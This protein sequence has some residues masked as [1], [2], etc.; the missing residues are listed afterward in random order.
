MRVWICT[1]RVANRE[2]RCGYRAD[3][4]GNDCSCTLPDGRN[5]PH[6]CHYRK[7]TGS[8]GHGMRA[9][10][11]QGCI[12]RSGQQGQCH[13]FLRLSHCI[14]RY[15]QWQTPS[16]PIE[17]QGVGVHPPHRCAKSVICRGCCSTC[18]LE[19]YRQAVPCLQGRGH[20]YSCCV[21]AHRLR[22]RAGCRGETHPIGI[23]K[24]HRCHG[25]CARMHLWRQGT[26]GKGHPLAGLCLCICQCIHLHDLSGLP[27]CKHHDDTAVRSRLIIPGCR[28]AS[29][30]MGQGDDDRGRRC[31]VQL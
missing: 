18:N 17:L 19:C 5:G 30:G 20:R 9:A 25:R 24:P 28:P 8:E 23:L 12:P 6:Q 1:Q 11:C 22:R 3:T 29:Q 14:C 10:P 2:W 16:G 21:G 15:Q 27:C 13:G 26:K 4:H 31:R 7:H